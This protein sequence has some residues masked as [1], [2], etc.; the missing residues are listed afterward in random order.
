MNLKRFITENSASETIISAKKITRL[1]KITVNENELSI[2]EEP[3]IFKDRIIE[4]IN[5]AKY[6]IC[7]CALYLQNDEA[8]NEILTALY[9]AQEKNPNL[10]ITI[11]VDFHRAQRGLCG[12]GPQIGNNVW[13]Q[14]MAQ[15]FSGTVK[16]FGIPV[17]KRELFGVLHLKGF[18]FDD[19]L[20]YS[21]ASINNVYLSYYSKYRMDRYHIIDSKKLADAFCNYCIKAFHQTKAITDLTKNNLPSYKE[22][23][24]EIKKQ[25]DILSNLH[26]DFIADTLNDKQIGITPLV[27]LGKRKNQ[28]NQTI[29]N[30]I[31]SATN[32][33]FIH[34]PYFNFPRRVLVAVNHALARNVKVTIMVGD[35]SAND[36]YIKRDETFNK[37]GAIPYLY[38]QNLKKFIKMHTFYI[39]NKLLNVKLWKD[40]DNTYHVKGMSIDNSYHL[41]TGN[42]LNPRA[43]GLDLEN[44]ILVHDTHQLLLAKFLHERNYL[45]LKTMDITNANQL[46]HFEQYPEQVKRILLRVKK[47]GIQWLL[48]KLL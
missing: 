46:E 2:L 17:K 35:K 14:Q 1:P 37:V 8:G 25:K 19:T 21:G 9:Q 22:L 6:R 10:D 32:E 38:E 5:S 34:T 47:L 18:V 36:F 31:N 48:K 7:M 40:T 30:L 45:L 26:Y 3:K 15:K 13:Y 29:V 24:G 43:W 23:T 41:I 39:N 11:Y 12:K 44:G 4:L 27:G 16:I 20:L 42:N 33:I 28:L